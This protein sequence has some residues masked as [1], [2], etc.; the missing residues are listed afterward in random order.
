MHPYRLEITLRIRH[1]SLEFRNITKA[2]SVRPTWGWTAGD[3]RVTPVGTP[4]P[5]G[6]RRKITYWYRSLPI[7]RKAP[8]N[9][10]LKSL[11]HRFSRHK[12]F[13]AR[14]RREGGSVEFFVFWHFERNSGDTLD[15]EV[16]KGLS[17]LQIDLALDLYPPPRP[18]RK[19]S[20]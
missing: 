8:L 18:V 17:D 7:T 1:P 10:T 4:C 2:L 5:G 13:F 15:Q 11:V 6:G 14:M 12:K 20:R 19:R 9:K 16:L 3:P